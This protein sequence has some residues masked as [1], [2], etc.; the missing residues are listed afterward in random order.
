M[1]VITKNNQKHQR[2]T[3]VTVLHGLAVFLLQSTPRIIDLIYPRSRQNL[4]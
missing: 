1:L 2:M 4:C 3:Y